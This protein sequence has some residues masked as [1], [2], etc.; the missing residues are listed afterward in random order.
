MKRII[1][2]NDMNNPREGHFVLDSI[3]RKFLKKMFGLLRDKDAIAITGSC[4]VALTLEQEG[5]PSFLPGDIDVFV[6]QD[7]KVE[8]EIFDRHFLHSSILLPLLSIEGINWQPKEIPITKSLSSK[9]AK[10]RSCKIN[11][12]HIIEICLFQENKEVNAE[13]VNRPKIQIIIVGDETDIPQEL[14]VL[15]LTP[16]EKKVVTSFDI[17]IVKGTYNPMTNGI[18]FAHPDIKQNVLTMRF[19]YIC[20]VDRSFSLFS[21]CE[22][23]KKYID[24]GFTFQGLKDIDNPSIRIATPK[25]EITNLQ[26]LQFGINDYINNSVP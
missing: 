23:V 6:K 17:D 5:Y 14:P 7:L 3:T 18:V 4:I 13:I 2:N 8:N 25:F 15:S 1:S 12:L 26:S 19:W 21:T 9:Y 22:R 16:F 24:R 11:I 10:Y 20:D